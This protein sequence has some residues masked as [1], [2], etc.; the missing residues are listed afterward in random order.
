LRHTPVDTTDHTLK[1]NAGDMHV[2]FN[3]NALAAAVLAALTSTSAQAIQFDTA[4]AP[5]MV[6]RNGF[7]TD[8]LVTSGEATPFD[9]NGTVANGGLGSSTPV[10]IM[11]GIG[12]YKLNDTTVRALVNQE[13]NSGTGNSYGL[14]N[15]VTLN[16]ARVSFFDIDINTRKVTNAGLAYDKAY[17]R[18]GN[19]VTSASQIETG[20]FQRFCS[21]QLFEAESFGAGRGLA[22]RIY[23]TNEETNNG[24]V[25]ALDTATNSIWAAPAMGRG[26]WENVALVD[27]GLTD[28]V[29]FVMGDD[30]NGQ[31]LMMY[32]GTKSGT[33][34]LGR[35]GLANGEIFVWSADNGAT[36]SSATAGFGATLAGTFKKI[37]SFDASKAGT[38]GY[39]ALGY[40]DQGTM[41]ADAFDANT[42]A[43]A[44]SRPEDVDTS[45][46]DPT[47]VAIAI[48][49]ATSK[50]NFGGT[51]GAPSTYDLQ[52]VWGKTGIL[53]LDFSQ[54][55]SGGAITAV[56]RTIHDG[57]EDFAQAGNAPVEVRS[58]DN[59]D[60]A[61]DGKVYVNE[62]RSAD[63]TAEN[64][65]LEDSTGAST[66]DKRQAAILQIDPIT[67]NVVRIAEADVDVDFS[68]IGASL[69]QAQK[70]DVG[71]WESSGVLDVS[72]LFGKAAGTLFLTDTQL[73]NLRNGNI[74]YTGNRNTALVEGGQLLLLGTPDSIAPVPVPAAAWLFASALGGLAASRRR[75]A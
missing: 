9:F 51:V 49:G 52:D 26:G 45:S 21:S 65:H 23:F 44:F 31:P 41:A 63:W 72:A 66:T 12:A 50:T 36:A 71:N 43:Y 28:K 13:L 70:D 48:T 22:D 75:K 35:N 68:S 6:G 32:V 11:D 58:A 73:H 3:Q 37:T 27:T 29:A 25:W 5:T 42:N 67:G 30:T 16:G 62:D 60:W 2:N 59:L 34:F 57:N 18:A 56:W 4:I 14:A 74:A 53:D 19:F 39:D 20:A 61:D 24:S 38:A 55:G 1:L 69:T 17:D 47:Q 33:D 54:L 8:A 64:N 7:V 46:A 10:G 40:A 15:G